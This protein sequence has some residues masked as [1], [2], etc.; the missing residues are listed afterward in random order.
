MYFQYG[1]L[2][3]NYLSQKDPGMKKA[4]E[5]IG[6]INRPVM[7]NLF[8]GL[9]SSI[10]AQ[11]ISS[12]AALTVWS[13]FKEL[14]GDV[15]PEN[16]A[17]MDLKEIQKQGMS[18]RKAGYLKEIASRITKGDFD[19]NG[20]EGMTDD[21][22]VKS[23]KS[24]PGIGIWTAEMLMI[25]SMQRS[26]ILSWDDLAIRRGMMRLYGYETLDRKTFEEYRLIYAPYG[27]VASLYLWALSV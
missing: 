20:L 22:V 6:H 18:F 9:M 19:L 1:D 23:L 11:Q 13:R 5:E 24:L 16:V 7:P 12:K 26:N 10:I 21:A 2:E 14:V 4:I 27:S 15:T 25:F 17:E 8:E 3:K